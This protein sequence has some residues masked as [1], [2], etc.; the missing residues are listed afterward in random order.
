MPFQT[1]P[2]DTLFSASQTHENS[3]RGAKEE[4]KLRI[5][6]MYNLKENSNKKL[7]ARTLINEYSKATKQLND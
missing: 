7:K 6:E 1:T 2:K 5:Q 4:E 3:N